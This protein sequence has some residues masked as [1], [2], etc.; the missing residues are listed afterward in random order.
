MR[1]RAKQSQEKG[2]DRRP[3]VK[4]LHAA[5]LRSFREQ[6]REKMVCA[7]GVP[8]VIGTFKKA[9]SHFEPSQTGTGTA[10]PR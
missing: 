7:R 2:E 1:R 10:L 6:H 8:G 5:L 9:N 4:K 3:T